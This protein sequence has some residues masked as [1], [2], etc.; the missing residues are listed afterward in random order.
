MWASMPTGRVM[1][2]D[3]DPVPDGN[4]VVGEPDAGGYR[5]GRVL[6]DGEIPDPD[7][8]RYVSHFATCPHADA[9]RRR[10]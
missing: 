7:V 6:S 3:V 10:P 1:P 9:H 2:V 5:R 8:E 4:V